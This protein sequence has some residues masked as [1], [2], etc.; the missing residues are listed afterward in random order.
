MEF[1]KYN[2]YGEGVGNR[3]TCWAA[4]DRGFL[5]KQQSEGWCCPGLLYMTGKEAGREQGTELREWLF[6]GDNVETYSNALGPLGVWGNVTRKGSFQH[7]Y[8]ICLLEAVQIIR[9]QGQGWKSIREVPRPRS[10]SSANP[11]LGLAT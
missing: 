7:G 3:I 5:E 2:R 4:G 10:Y 11:M 1:F 8:A 6:P 9:S